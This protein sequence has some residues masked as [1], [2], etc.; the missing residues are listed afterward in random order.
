MAWKDIITA[1]APTIGLAL[2]SP[3]G[4]I[5]SSAIKGALGL[6][7]DSKEA[8]IEKALAANPALYAEIKKAE[9]LFKQK[10][11]ELEIDVEQIHAADRNNARAREIAVKDKVP[12]ILAIV[13]TLG[14]FGTLG[15]MMRYGIPD[16]G[17]EALLVM[18]G[19]LGAAWGGVTAYYFGSSVGSAK[20]DHIMMNK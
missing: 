8:D 19:S 1:I 18:L 2:N 20:K 6:E 3:L 13:I 5:A 7:N 17:G 14:F 9:I 4:S 16:S 11:A 10:M 15:Y 12:A